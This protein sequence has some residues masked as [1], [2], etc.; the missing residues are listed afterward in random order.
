[1]QKEISR[2]VELIALSLGVVGLMNAQFAVKGNEV[3]VIEVNP[4]AS[5][6]V[7]FVSKAIGLPLA[8][9]AA[10]CMVGTTLAAQGIVQAPTF[11]GFAVKEAVFP[12]L[13]FASVDPILGP[14]MRST[15][16][17]MGIARDFGEAFFKAQLAAGNVLPRTGSALLSVRDADKPA[18]LDI[19]RA[20]RCKGFKLLATRATAQ[21]LKEAGIPCQFVYKVTD[22]GRPHIV[23]RIQNGEVDLV[24]NTTEGKQATADSFTIRRNAILHKVCYTT[25]IAGASAIVQALESEDYQ[26]HRLDASRE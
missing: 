23:D 7:P 3:Y 10:H 24:I 5:R 22:H 16:E 11:T 9:I 2:Q 6:T 14:E 18:T 21:M 26:V 15:G 13:K 1:M 17:V 19:A 12:F 8:K 25:T 4:R 20:L